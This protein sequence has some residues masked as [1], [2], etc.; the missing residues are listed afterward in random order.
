NQ[1][2]SKYTAFIAVNEREEKI[3][4]VPVYQATVLEAPERWETCSP[5]VF[6]MYQLDPKPL[7]IGVKP[8]S[9][10]KVLGTL[11]LKT[12]DTR[13]RTKP[14]PPTEKQIQQSNKT[15]ASKKK[16][17]AIQPPKEKTK[18]W[19]K[20]FPFLKPKIKDKNARWLD[21][22]GVIYSADK[23]KLIGCRGN[24]HITEYKILPKCEV[25]C[26]KAFFG[27]TNLTSIYIPGSVKEIEY[28]AF[29]GPKLK[30]IYVGWDEIGI[31]QCLGLGYLFEAI[32]EDTPI[33]QADT[34]EELYAPVM[35][36]VQAGYLDTQDYINKLN[37]NLKSP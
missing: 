32:D 12:I 4:N 16:A 36:L 34:N 10:S 17:K 19:Y 25:I 2:D 11:D 33:Y 29:F 18:W 13:P 8:H 6:G 9:G 14:L 3:T 27:C 26:E 7:R 21:E 30:S 23:K 15:L 35:L 20:I 28:M 1:I 31:S 37:K 24:T 22:F 5:K